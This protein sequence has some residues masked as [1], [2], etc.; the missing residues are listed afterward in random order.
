MDGGTCTRAELLRYAQNNIP[1][2]AIMIEGSQESWITRFI[3]EYENK[4]VAQDGRA[5]KLQFQPQMLR[6]HPQNRLGYNPHVKIKSE[7]T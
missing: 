6:S 7:A 1:E 5:S 4:P 3:Q 2:F